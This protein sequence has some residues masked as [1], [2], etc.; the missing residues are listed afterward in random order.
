MNVNELP[1]YKCH[2]VVRAAKIIGVG[3]IGDNDAVALE[4]AFDDPCLI[5]PYGWTYKHRPEHGGYLV[6]YDDDYLSYS[7]AAAFEAG[8]SLIIDKDSNGTV[9]TQNADGTE[10]LHFQGSTPA[11]TEIDL[12]AA[13]FSDALIWLKEGKRVSRAGWNGKG[14]FVE[15]WRMSDRLSWPTGTNP[16][17]HVPMKS[18]FVLVNTQGEA[19]P[20]W[21]PSMGDLMA[22]DWKVVS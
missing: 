7:P 18:C 8:Y 17:Q 5:L 1:Q 9:L 15:I 10:T 14:Q 6:A 2:K 4:G 21:V 20:G 19:Q 3:R 12:D 11:S 13:D 22:D 16:S